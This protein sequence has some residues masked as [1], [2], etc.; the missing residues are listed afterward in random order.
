LC[1]TQHYSKYQSKYAV[2]KEGWFCGYYKLFGPNFKQMQETPSR[3][4]HHGLGIFPAMTFQLAFIFN[5]IYCL[6]L[7][8]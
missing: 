4:I 2:S 8:Q 7:I 3:F 1:S 5:S 6:P